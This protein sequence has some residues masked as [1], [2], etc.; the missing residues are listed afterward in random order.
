VIDKSGHIVTNDHVVADASDVR[1]SF[2]DNE[3]M[4]ARVVG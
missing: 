1:V 2:S 3:S 4:K